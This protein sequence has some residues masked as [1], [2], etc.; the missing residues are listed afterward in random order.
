GL[1][2]EQQHQEL[3]MTDL[4]HAFASN[5]LRPAYREAAAVGQVCNLPGE[6]AGYKPAPRTWESFP[7]AVREIGHEGGGFAFDNE[8]PRHRVFVE[9]FRIASRPATAGEYLAFVEDGGYERPEWWLSDGWQAR[10]AHGWRA[11]LY[12]ERRDGRW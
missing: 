8:T 3:L 11:P 7:A 10:Q 5:P 6:G 2:H 1:H 4:K 12:W 9:A